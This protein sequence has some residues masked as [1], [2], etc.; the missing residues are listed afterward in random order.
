MFE[1]FFERVSHRAKDI[2]AKAKAFAE[3]ERDAIENI[4]EVIDDWNDAVDDEIEDRIKD[5]QNY[6]SSLPQHAQ[7]EWAKLKTQRDQKIAE[8]R[9][10][11]ETR[12]AERQ[13]RKLNRSAEHAE[14]AAT[15]A[16]FFSLIAL[17]EAEESVLD[18]IDARSKA[19]AGIAA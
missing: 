13:Q 16:V 10:N 11:R 1:Q 9:S 15:T 12:K 3:D 2:Q 4:E 5:M 7:D 18:A 6:V 8:F 19:D 14:L 17:I